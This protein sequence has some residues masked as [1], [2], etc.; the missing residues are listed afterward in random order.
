MGNTFSDTEDEE[1]YA[2]HFADDEHR[3]NKQWEIQPLTNEARQDF[4]AT[5]EEATMTSVDIAETRRLLEDRYKVLPFETLRLAFHAA[6][7]EGQL[8]SWLTRLPFV[9]QL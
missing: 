3:V 9:H 8:P 4:L 6:P 1:S 7:S 5:I 2:Y